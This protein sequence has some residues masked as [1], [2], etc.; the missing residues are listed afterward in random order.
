MTLRVS[1]PAHRKNAA[2]HTA[3][4]FF[5]RY[6]IALSTVEYESICSSL[7]GRTDGHIATGYS[8]RLFFRIGYRHARCIAIWD[9]EIDCVVSFVPQLP[10][11]AT[12]VEVPV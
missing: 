4:R 12:P 8:G 10:I 2:I 5:E 6:G 3:R 7:R 9:P 1:E 11:T